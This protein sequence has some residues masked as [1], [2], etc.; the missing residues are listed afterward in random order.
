MSG[1]S[2]TPPPLAA[3]CGEQI[4]EVRRSIH[5]RLIGRIVSNIV[6]IYDET[7]IE[8]RIFVRLVKPNAAKI[9]I[10]RTVHWPVEQSSRQLELHDFGY[11][12]MWIAREHAVVRQPDH[13]GNS[14]WIGSEQP[15]ESGLLV[16]AELAASGHT[17][18]QVRLCR[19]GRHEVVRAPDERHADAK[20]VVRT[21]GY[22]RQTSPVVLRDFVPV[23]WLRN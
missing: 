17:A 22:R 15:I 1:S 6:V 3:H 20:A 21:R 9:L 14:P 16:F 12:G 11:H 10:N 2:G 5:D 23:A 13:H 4:G 8:R 7:G 19:E 18:V